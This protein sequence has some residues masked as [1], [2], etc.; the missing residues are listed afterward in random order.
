MSPPAVSV[1][2]PTRDRPEGLRRVLDALEGQTIREPFE[3]IVVDDQS[4]EPPTTVVADRPFEV[5]LLKG[6]GRGPAAARNAGWRAAAATV[7]AFTDDDTLPAPSW[8]AGAAK[9]AAK[10][11]EFVGIE[12]PTTTEPFDPLLQHSVFATGPGAWLTCNIAYR[13]EALEAVDGFYER[14]PAAH[15]EDLDLGLRISRLGPMAFDEGMTVEHTVRSVTLGH[16][17]LNGRIITSETVLFHRHPDRYQQEVRRRPV[18]RAVESR[19]RHWIRLMYADLGPTVRHPWRLGAW[20]LVL[21]GNTAV[22]VWHAR[23]FDVTSGVL[24][25]RATY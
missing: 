25:R 23:R 4:R 24:G 18:V 10:T 3:V 6:E 16:H 19:L 1:V 7:V 17:I 5:R 11:N 9:L 13:R 20:L 12:G 22:S 14:F 15:C 8:L 2:I 21:I